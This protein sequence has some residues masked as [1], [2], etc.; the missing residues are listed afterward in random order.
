MNIKHIIDSY[1]KISDGSDIIYF[2]YGVLKITVK[3]EI[4]GYVTRIN[5]DNFVTELS[6]ENI[7]NSILRAL[8]R[9][10]D[11]YDFDGYSDEAI[12]CAESLYHFLNTIDF[13]ANK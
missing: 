13:Y 9:I 3:K 12:D 2:E 1:K 5:G 7:L 6:N 8:K 4:K 11:E 10:F